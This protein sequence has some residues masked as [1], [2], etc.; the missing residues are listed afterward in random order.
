MLD[1]I[2]ENF[3][4]STKKLD[5]ILKPIEKELTLLEE[6]L[7]HNIL[8]G[9]RD[10]DKM[11]TYFFRSGGK[12]LR[13][14]IVI[15]FAKAISKGYLP[16]VNL[17]LAQAVE[18][19]HTA[20]LIH[21]DVIDNAETRRGVLTLNKQW[22]AKKAVIVG[23]YILSRALGKL[24][25]INT[26]AVEMFS[27]TLNELCVGE[28]MQKN[29]SYQI[30]SLEDYINKSERKTAKLFMAA[31]ECAAAITKGTNNLIIKA[32][33]GYSLN[34]GIA[35]QIVDDILDFTGNRQQTGK[36]A[37]GDLKNGIITAP[38]IF[39]NQQYEENGD[40]T[41]KKLIETKF[42]NEKDFK[43][44]LGIVMKSGGI[45][46][47]N[48]LAREYVEKA[49]GYLDVIEDSSYKQSLIDLAYY[50]L[51]RTS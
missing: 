42:R 28:I 22:G 23:D 33:R 4:N 31:T 20:S 34:F 2:T 17:E 35:F 30:I 45:E 50:T 36:P 43:R 40:L 21:D 8:S 6:N 32:T 25:K 46:K 37:A 3:T 27:N 13:P 41:L 11:V 15:L 24:I 5:A 10:L 48:K 7:I 12:R 39:A 51:K 49:V 19:V 44:A 14:A 38:V 1:I 29:Q 9:N 16:S 47:A 18:M 26:L